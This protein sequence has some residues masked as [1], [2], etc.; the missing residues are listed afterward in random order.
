MLDLRS[1]D[2]N[3]T[4]DVGKVLEVKSI[5]WQLYK[6]MRMLFRF[7]PTM[8]STMHLDTKEKGIYT[9]DIGFSLVNQMINHCEETGYTTRKLYIIAQELNKL[10]IVL[11]DVLQYFQ[12]FIRPDFKQKPDI[13]NATEKYKEMADKR[14]VD[15]L[16]S[17]VGKHH[18][19]NWDEL[20]STR[21]AMNKTEEYNRIVDGRR[22]SQ[23]Q[24][25]IYD[26]DDQGEDDYDEIENDG[27]K[28]VKE[29]E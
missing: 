2:M 19:I 17:L 7:N 23:E 1:I 8:R 20:G 10:E 5:L 22:E 18:T 15:E 3:M 25:N 13:E 16:R 28:T 24:P 21:I 29:E 27:S 9:T 4:Y 26:D 11:K 6:N 14:T 12:Y